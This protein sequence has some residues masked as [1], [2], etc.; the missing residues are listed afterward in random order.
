MAKGQQRSNKEQRKQKSA[1]KKTGPKYMQTPD[2]T[3]VAKLGATRPGP[4]K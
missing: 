3:P 4:K 2:L 1:D